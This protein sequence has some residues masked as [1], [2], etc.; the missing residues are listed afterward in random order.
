MES[1]TRGTQVMTLNESSGSHESEDGENEHPPY[2]PPPRVYTA[3]KP[4]IERALSRSLAAPIVERKLAAAKTK[5]ESLAALATPPPTPNIE[6][7]RPRTVATERRR[8]R[9]ME[10]VFGQPEAKREKPSDPLQSTQAQRNIDILYDMYA[11]MG[12]VG[13]RIVRKASFVAILPASIRDGSHA[14]ELTPRVLRNEILAN[15]MLHQTQQSAQE[16]STLLQKNHNVTS[17]N[18]ETTL[19]DI[20]AGDAQFI[21][22]TAT[23]LFVN[24]SAT[25]KRLKVLASALA[26]L[27][28]RKAHLQSVV[29]ILDARCAETENNLRVYREARD[30][31]TRAGSGQAG[32]TQ[33]LE[34]VIRDSQ[35]QHDLFKARLELLRGASK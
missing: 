35:R 19:E 24:G 23:K 33:S 27:A 18:L 29:R 12:G 8:K 25:S 11:A 7:E 15:Q 34:A 30:V 2:E 32:L 10:E 21:R 9:K 28:A 26:D 17:T 5:K 16:Q 4:S 3:P 1:I 14:K 31:S 22:W 13:G 6:S 20:P